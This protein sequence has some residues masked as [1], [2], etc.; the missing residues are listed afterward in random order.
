MNL[1]HLPITCCS[2]RSVCVLDDG[3]LILYAPEGGAINDFLVCHMTG[4]C[5]A[6]AVAFK[7]P[8][9][10]YDR[11]TIEALRMDYRLSP[12]VQARLQAVSPVMVKGEPVARPEA[13][14]KKRRGRP[15]GS[16]LKPRVAK[17]PEQSKEC[18]DSRKKWIT[19]LLSC[20]ILSK[21][22]KEEDRHKLIARLLH[23]HY[24]LQGSSD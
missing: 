6:K 5:G 12:E 21:L 10:R 2:C 4:A 3:S 1:Y 9:R 13:P 14:P 23:A 11:E 18:A 19:V 24:R 15:P 7:G 16:K 22:G 20:S 17:D 8:R